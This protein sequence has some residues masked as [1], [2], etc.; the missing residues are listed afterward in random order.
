[1]A[2]SDASDCSGLYSSGHYRP[3]IDDGLS[4]GSDIDA[5]ASAG[6][7]ASI[8]D[9]E[10]READQPLALHLAQ[11]MLPHATATGFIQYSVGGKRGKVVPRLLSLQA[12]LLAAVLGKLGQSRL[13]LKIAMA[14]IRQVYSMRSWVVDKEDEAIS[15]LAKRL[16]TMVAHFMRARNLPQPPAW[17]QQVCVVSRSRLQTPTEKENGLHIT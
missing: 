8:A 15:T 3:D 2:A 16:Q 12:K 6:S 9:E 1:M 10:P 14:A 4:A 5:D 7:D 11:A 17:L 13:T